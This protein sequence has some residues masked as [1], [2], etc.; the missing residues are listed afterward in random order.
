MRARSLISQDILWLRFA[1]TQY[2]YIVT[3]LLDAQQ[4]SIKYKYWFIWC[5]NWKERHHNA[6]RLLNRDDNDDDVFNDCFDR[7]NVN[8]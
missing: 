4:G 2:N 3:I 8:Q 6:Q 5:G 1:T 7:Q